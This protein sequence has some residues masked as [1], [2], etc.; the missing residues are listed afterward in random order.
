MKDHYGILGVP[1]N[2]AQAWI[3]REYK[4][5]VD[6]LNG[7]SRLKAA[8][9]QK[10]LDALADAHAVLS[11]PASRQVFDAELAASRESGS[12]SSSLMGRLAVPIIAV[13]LLALGGGY[14]Y[15]QQ[16]Q[17]RI[18]AEEQERERI[19]EEKRAAERAAEAKRREAA[20]VAEAEARRVAEEQRLRDAAAAREV[21]M[22]SQQFVAGKPL[23]RPKTAEEL[24][25]ER[26]SQFGKVIER[27]MDQIEEDRRRFQSQEELRR[28]Q[29]F[30]EQR[31][32]EEDQAVRDRA[33]AAR[34]AEF[35]DRQNR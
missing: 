31:Q 9:R 6:A 21:E 2:A 22:Q 20:A 4:K 34:N 17:K 8:D 10:S 25:E 29:R 19:A 1:E 16:E 27:R 30:L 28:Q 13:L 35:R 23:P 7:D 18:I 24:R 3:D 33:N 14:Y 15:Y 12:G 26:L 5:R 11:N 32:R